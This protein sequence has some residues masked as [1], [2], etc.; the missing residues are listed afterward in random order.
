M[1]PSFCSE[2]FSQFHIETMIIA[3]CSVDVGGSLIKT[4]EFLYRIFKFVYR[5]Q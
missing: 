2:R 3:G 4:S 5:R 1:M